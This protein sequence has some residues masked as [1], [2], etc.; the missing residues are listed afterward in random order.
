MEGVQ[1]AAGPLSGLRI[2]EFAG[3]GP[4]PFCGMML[5]DQ[6]AEVIR[7]DRP[8]ARFDPFDVLARSRRALSVD[9]K[10]PDGLALVRELCREADGLIEGFRP[11][12]ME[13]LGL[14][15]DVLLADNRRLVFGRMTGWGQTGPL[16]GA[17]GH[18]INYIG[19]NGVLH[20]VG[21]AGAKPVV[22]VN[23]VGDFGGGGMLLAFGMAAALASAARSGVGQVVDAAMVDGSA[24]LSAMTWQFR[25][26]GMWNDVAGSN[27]LD[28][29]AH[30]YG[31]YE[32][33]DGKSVA[34]GAV[35]PQFYRVLLERLGL[36][37]DPAFKA[38]RDE[39]A[40]PDQ[41]ARLA[42]LFRTRTR[43]DWCAVMEGA[44]ACFAPVLTMS[45]APLHPHIAGR[46]T[47]ITVAGQ[48][49]PAPAPRFSSG[50]AAPPRPPI[51]PERE[52]DTTL[53][54]LGYAAERIAE[55]RAAG[56]I[57]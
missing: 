38:Q 44:D 57:A 21:V 25:A 29:G 24:L 33:S 50:A 36:A 6:G 12:V 2:I 4:G 5:A 56:A 35:E 16:A 55:L 46:E 34:V 7:V 40:W 48:M 10:H 39:A 49:Q 15:P 14:G 47:F 8:G 17:A 30:F 54:A 19:L 37:D 20:T 52:T 43:D 27:L 42:A 18:D 3:V 26:R 22:P 13:R 31:V 45:E 53:A 32:C 28:G 51:H 23:Y 1:P 11:G 9:V 41:K